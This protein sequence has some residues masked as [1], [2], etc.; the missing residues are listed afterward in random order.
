MKYVII[1]MPKELSFLKGPNILRFTKEGK[2]TLSKKW[3]YVIAEQ[4]TITMI[5]EMNNL[6]ESRRGI[7]WN[8][9]IKLMGGFKGA[10]SFH[11]NAFIFFVELRAPAISNIN[12]WKTGRTLSRNK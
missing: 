10:A 4:S 12:G 6:S 5:C 8:E 7:S 2:S 9:F 11:A 3:V 1:F